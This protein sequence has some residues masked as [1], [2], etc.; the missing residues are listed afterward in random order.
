MS[1]RDV[2]PFQFACPTCEERISFVFGRPDAELQGAE[3]LEFDGPFKGDKPFVDLHLDFPVYFGKYVM[4]MT[5]FFRVTGEIGMEAYHHLN[6]RLHIL[7][8]LHPMERDLASLISQYKR[9]DLST[10]EKVCERIP[11]VSL[12]S[13]KKQDVLA[14]LYSATSVM[15][16]PFTIHEHNS[17]ISERAPQLYFWLHEH[18]PEKMLAFFDRI[19]DSGFLKN[20]HNDCLSLYPR[21]VSMD[22]PFRPAFFYDYA[23]TEQLGQIPARI[24]TADFDTCN[25][26]YKDLAEVFS[27]QVTLLAGL[28]NLLK[29]GDFDL[30]EPSLKITKKGTRAEL[31]NL[32]A[33][34]NV[35]L[36]NK[37]GFVDDCFYRI[38][39]DAIDNKL[40]NAIAHYKF[41]YKESTQCITYYPSKE[42]MSR[43]KYHEISFM[44]FIRKSLLLFREVHSVNH[45]IKATLFYCVLALKR[46]I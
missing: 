27:R 36:G 11:G 41:E 12:K 30:F 33:F 8:W 9:G 18:H 19:I 34:A 3:E 39:I 44:D 45:I 21:L 15:S 4:G 2:Q 31:E 22:L 42:G 28:N 17:E 10:F 38:D 24:S 37:I 16:S 32:N 43:E 46:D 6:H 35:D 29:R 23:D 5:T 14:A 1:N 25:T 26:Y 20:L 13:R 7:N 40:R